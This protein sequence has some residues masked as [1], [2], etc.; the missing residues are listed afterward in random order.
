[1]TQPPHR[2]AHPVFSVNN[3]LLTNVEHFTYLG[4]VLSADCDITH[5]VQQRIRSASAAFGRLYSRVF[6]NYN[7]TT[8]SK[9][10]VHVHF[11]S[12]LLQCILDSKQASFQGTRGIPRQMSSVQA[13]LGVHW[14]HKVTHSDLCR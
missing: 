12:T 7:L 1:M 4:S 10:T 9:V 2:G 14:W 11:N 6:F 13:I 3:V 5:K 8:D